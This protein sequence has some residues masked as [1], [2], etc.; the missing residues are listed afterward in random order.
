MVEAARL[1]LLALS[2]WKQ[3]QADMEG[4]RWASNRAEL[5]ALTVSLQIWGV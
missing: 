1:C 2:Q 4:E 5:K 3:I